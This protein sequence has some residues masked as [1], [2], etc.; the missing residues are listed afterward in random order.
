MKYPTTEGKNGPIYHIAT[1]IYVGQNPHGNW[2]VIIRA[3]DKRKRKSC[4]KSQEGMTKA[5]KMA[6]LM[7]AKMGLL[8]E[9]TSEKTFSDV[10]DE[11]V[12][13]NQQRWSPNTLERYSGILKDFVKPVLGGYPLATVTRNRV[14]E[15]LTPGGQD[16]ISKVSRTGACCRERRVQRGYRVGV[17]EGK[18]GAWASQESIAAEKEA[19]QTNA[20]STFSG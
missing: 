8:E 6:E 19:T 14:R 5:I 16:T 18:P 3:Q 12:T 17:Y 20:R 11:W 1:G 4:G 13:L 15:L 9:P 7:A 2:E 10:A